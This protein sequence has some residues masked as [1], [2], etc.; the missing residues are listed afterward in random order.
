MMA[1]VKVVDLWEEGEST[2]NPPEA[3][4]RAQSGGEMLDPFLATVYVDEYLLIRVQHSVDEKPALI[5]S[6]SLASD[7]LRLFGPGEEGVTPILAP[8]KSTDWDAT[9]DGLGFTMNSH[10]IR[11]SFPREKADAIKKLLR[12]QWPASRRQAKAKD[13]LI[14]AGKLWNRT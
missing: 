7:H 2:S 9:I 13:V 8:K 6:A 3:K 4:I 11:I 14:M 10:I 12:D 5:A 1:H